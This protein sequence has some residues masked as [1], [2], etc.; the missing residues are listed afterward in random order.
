L[1]LLLLLPPLQVHF[2]SIDLELH[3]RFAPGAGESVF[4]RD[5]AVAQKTQVRSVYVGLLAEQP[6]QLLRLSCQQW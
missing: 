1:L 5:A 4:D 3:S 6:Q 2:S